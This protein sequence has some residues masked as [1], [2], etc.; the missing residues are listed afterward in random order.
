LRGGRNADIRL[1]YNLSDGNTDYVYAMK[2]E[3][4]VFTTVPLTQLKPLKNW[5]TDARVD[6]QYYVRPHLPL[7]APYAYEEYRVED[8][9]FNTNVLNALNP[10]NASNNTFASTIYSGYVYR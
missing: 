5:L 3:Q 7:R 2:P 10:V 4:K 8:F 1:I 9:S 6:V